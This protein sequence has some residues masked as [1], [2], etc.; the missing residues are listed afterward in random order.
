MPTE[1]SGSGGASFSSVV[2]RQSEGEIIDRITQGEHATLD[3][4]LQCAP[5]IHDTSLSV[6]VMDQAQTP[7]ICYPDIPHA[8]PLQAD[9]SRSASIRIS[10]GML[11]LNAGRYSFVLALT[12]KGSARCLCRQQGISPF[13]VTSTAV[14]WGS[15]VRT[16]TPQTLSH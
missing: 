2:M 11:D 14:H 9:G 12:E 3:F 7:I 15:I 1:E 16:A 4:Q 10:L 5:G 6:Y 8:L 13:Q